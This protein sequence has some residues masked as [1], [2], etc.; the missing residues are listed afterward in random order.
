MDSLKLVVLRVQFASW[1]SD[2]D[3]T[4]LFT[5]TVELLCWER[6]DQLLRWKREHNYEPQLCEERADHTPLA[7][8]T[9]GE[10]TEPF[11]W[12]REVLMAHSDTSKRTP[13]SSRLWPCRASSIMDAGI[14]T[15]VSPSVSPDSNS[16]DE[17][18]QL[19]VFGEGTTTRRTACA[20]GTVGS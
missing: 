19:V 15:D 20:K 2:I 18:F 11:T 16:D 13:H 10:S 7:R 12:R 8:T 9:V 17:T 6:A 5:S 3:T 4:K 1:V 14:C